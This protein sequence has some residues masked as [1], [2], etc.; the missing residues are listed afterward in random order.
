MGPEARSVPRR[1]S[2]GSDG[3]SKCHPIRGRVDGGTLDRSDG[4]RLHFSDRESTAAQATVRETR[5]SAGGEY[6]VRQACP[7]KE[8][9]RTLELNRLRVKCR[10][11]IEHELRSSIRPGRCTRPGSGHPRSTHSAL[12][13]AARRRLA[14]TAQTAARRRATKPQPRRSMRS[15]LHRSRPPQTGLYRAVPT[16]QGGSRSRRTVLSRRSLRARPLLRKSA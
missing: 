13:G 7:V 9:M 6:I 2:A 5:M 8:R 3:A 4:V 12:R 15:R 1:W 10:V 11:S 14:S 16:G